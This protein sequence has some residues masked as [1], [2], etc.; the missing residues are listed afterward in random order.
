MAH[1]DVVLLLALGQADLV[2][3]HG[4]IA[5]VPH[6]SVLRGDG[7]VEFGVESQALLVIGVSAALVVAGG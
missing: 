5:V 1:A 4:Q 2:V 6:Q 3:A 7:I